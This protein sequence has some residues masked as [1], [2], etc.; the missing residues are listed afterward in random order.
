MRSTATQT[1]EEYL[2]NLNCTGCSKHYPL[3]APKCSVGT[4]QAEKAKVEYEATIKQ[5]QS[6]DNSA[7]PQTLKNFLAGLTCTLCPK[8]CLLINPGCSKGE[9]QV[10]IA[11]KE[12]YSNIVTTSEEQDES[13]DIIIV[14][15]TDFLPIMGLY[16]AGTHYLVMIPK[17]L[18][19][20]SI[21]R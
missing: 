9:E 4:A 5:S 1:L 11:T 18:K 21:K 16:I 14:T 20:K 8:H 17:Y 12:Y 10:A 3:S 6:T 2:S 19:E 15:L 7:S 13:E